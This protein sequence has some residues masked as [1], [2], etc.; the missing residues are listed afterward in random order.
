MKEIQLTQGKVALVDDEDYDYLSQWKWYAHKTSPKA[1]TFYAV[2][3]KRKDEDINHGRVYMHREILRCKLEQPCDHK[4]NNGLNNQKH[5]LRACSVS[6]NRANQQKG[7]RNSSQ[8]K[9]VCYFKNRGYGNAWIA[10]IQANKKRY[11]LGYYKNETEAA[12]A[13]NNKAI[14]IH[15]EFAKLNIIK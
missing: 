3:T 7:A 12:I 2:R 4:D 13:Y 6:Q 1:H 8:Y 5:N 14:E 10:Y 11:N 9:G 15:G